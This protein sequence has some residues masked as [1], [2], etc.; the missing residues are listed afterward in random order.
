MKEVNFVLKVL[1]VLAFVCQWSANAKPSLHPHHYKNYS[2][3]KVEIDSHQDIKVIKSLP[4][5]VKIWLNPHLGDVAAILVPPDLHEST[6]E[7]LQDKGMEFKITQQDLQKEIDHEKAVDLQSKKSHKAMS[8][9]VKHNMT[10]DAYHD[11]EEFKS[12]YK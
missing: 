9:L 4:K 3:V 12:F 6:L 10:W 11:E 2:L 1:A 5:E 8:D 7:T